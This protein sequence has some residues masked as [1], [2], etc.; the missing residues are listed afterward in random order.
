MLVGTS[1]EGLLGDASASSAPPR[2]VQFRCD[3]YPG[4]LRIRALN[5]GG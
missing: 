4:R 5:E 2:K 3:L 1:L